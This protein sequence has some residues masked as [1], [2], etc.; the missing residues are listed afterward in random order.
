MA[1]GKGQWWDL[2]LED[3]SKDEL[4]DCLRAYK[5][6]DLWWVLSMGFEMERW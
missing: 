4:R 3:S 2:R 1:F 5:K 6:G